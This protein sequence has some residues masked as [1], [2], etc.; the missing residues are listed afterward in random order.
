MVEQFLTEPTKQLDVSLS[1]DK[2]I[3]IYI[4]SLMLAP[5]DYRDVE[6]IFIL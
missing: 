3:M 4:D 2:D 1:D 5:R 6:L